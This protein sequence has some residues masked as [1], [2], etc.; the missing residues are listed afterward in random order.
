VS[1]R[2]LDPLQAAFI[3]IIS[4]ELRTPLAEIMAAASVL[5]DGYTGS[6]NDQQRHYL[7][8]IELSA[9]NLDKIIKD[10]LSFAQMQ[11]DVIET[12]SEPTPL[13]DLVRAALDLNRGQMERKRLCLILRLGDDLPPLSLDRI[14]MA[15][16]CS[17]LISNAVSFTR[18]GGRIM[19]RTRKEG[20]GQ[21]LDVADN[22][23]GIPEVRQ[24]HVF[25]SFYQAEDPMT[26][27]TGGLGIGLAY[28]RR[29]VEAHGGRITFESIEGRGSMFTVWLPMN[30]HVLQDA[31]IN[32]Y[33]T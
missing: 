4:H 15:R 27:Q 13:G 31:D 1:Q 7:E 32:R 30:R 16:V 17:N 24:A 26:R 2:K 33:L 5:G 9:A 10:L 8:M 20:E 11:A 18:E 14:K 22:G 6:L 19:I 28:A 25:E 29:I 23:I 12:L 3:A 21:A